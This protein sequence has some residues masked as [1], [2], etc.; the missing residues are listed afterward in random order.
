MEKKRHSLP[1]PP[2]FSSYARSLPSP[3]QSYIN[4]D[5][6]LVAAACV[7]RL[8]NHLRYATRHELARDNRNR[9]GIG[10][11]PY[12]L[13]LPAIQHA[14]KYLDTVAAGQ[15]RC[16]HLVIGYKGR[17]RSA[18]LRRKSLF[19]A[20]IARNF[21]SN[22]SRIERF[23]DLR[24][25]ASVCGIQGAGTLSVTVRAPSPLPSVR[26]ARF[27]RFVTVIADRFNIVRR[28]VSTV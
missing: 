27:A 14:Y 11:P 12:L 16:I 21:A 17:V 18:R 24:G 9:P 23:E 28:S 4:Y 5:K 19:I 25:R 13:N 26:F 6:K 8:I 20:V 1:F 10:H 15:T 2:F 22:V 3:P 7:Q